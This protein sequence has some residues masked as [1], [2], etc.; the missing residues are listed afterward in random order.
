MH[1]TAAQPDTEA[2]ITSLDNL[3]SRADYSLLNNLTPD[4]AATADG[5]DHD[6]RQVYSGHYVPVKPTPLA[7]PPTCRRHPR[8]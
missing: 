4:P 5:N 8:G 6:P 3:A 7:E 1:N 2:P